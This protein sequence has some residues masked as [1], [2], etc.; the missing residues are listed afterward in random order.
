MVQR[1]VSGGSAGGLQRGGGVPD[2]QGGLGVTAQKSAHEVANCASRHYI[3]A[4]CCHHLH[5]HVR[6]TS[7]CSL[8]AL[9]NA[10]TKC[11]RQMVVKQVAT[12][13]HNILVEC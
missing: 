2:G 1:G 6:T 3:A 9:L 8:L 4:G 7:G 11:C 12:T 10:E 13:Y 5:Y